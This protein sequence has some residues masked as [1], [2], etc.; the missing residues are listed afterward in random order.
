VQPGRF[1]VD[2]DFDWA[3]GVRMAMALLPP[4][5]FGFGRSS[6]PLSHLFYTSPEP[7]ASATWEDIDG[8]MLVELRGTNT[9]G[10]LGHQ[11]MVPPSIHPTG[12]RLVRPGEP[13][14]RHSD[15]EIAHVEHLSEAVRNY[16]IACLFLKHL[17]HDG[18]KHHLKLALPGFLLKTGNTPDDVMAICR[19]L[20]RAT[21]NN[22][23]DTERAVQSTIDRFRR[24]E[25][26]KGASEIT[27]TLGNDIGRKVIARVRQWLGAGDW[28]RGDR[29]G[30]VASSPQN[31]RLAL[32]RMRVKATFNE[33]S[34]KPYVAIGDGPPKLVA[35]AVFIPLRLDVHTQ[36]GWLPSKELFVDVL[37]TVCWEHPF[38]PVRDYLHGLTWDGT[39]RITRWLVTYGK[40]KETEFVRAVGKLFLVAAVRRVMHPGCKFDEMLVLES[41]QGKAKSSAVS[42]LVPDEE[43]FTD[44][45]KLDADTK[46]LIEG[47][48]GKWIIEAGELAGM[49]PA[50]VEHLKAML[51]RQVDGPVRMA[52]ARESEERPRHF[53]IFGTTN[54]QEYLH[55]STGNR[56]FWPVRV[57]HFDIDSLRRDRD[58]LWAEAVVREAT[59]ESIR[60]PESLYPAA[61]KVQEKRRSED[62]WEETIDTML[63]G[64]DVHNNVTYVRASEVW[65]ALGLTTD[66]RDK[67]KSKR[68][69]EV[70]QRFG[71]V[72]DTLRLPVME[73]V[74]EGYDYI[75]VEST[76]GR[77]APTAV[78]RL[79]RLEEKGQSPLDYDGDDGDDRHE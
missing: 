28:E 55:D 37:K 31:V 71:W 29:G 7:L 27:A 48:A 58:Q 75:Y 50:R 30:I 51:S 15:G 19:A 21:R 43:W 38:H 11:T 74:K 70:M 20:V 53:V 41:G 52:Y 25:K 17:G 67:S 10:S 42:A 12:E 18:L 62:P 3:E 64:A 54:T 65:Q 61:A 66:K 59:D 22:E 69:S 57:G 39:P 44:D 77:T 26:V 60:L 73:R 36:F 9:D 1:L 4:T 13:V 46:E 6:K 45:F 24:N 5:D 63:K 8:S 34:Q 49:T 76:D 40:A 47:T 2:V 79:P 14:V 78:W 16:A 56:R 35:D 33:F 68:V 72:R 32:E 23:T